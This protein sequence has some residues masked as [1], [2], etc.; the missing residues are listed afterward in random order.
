MGPPLH[1]SN[2]GSSKEHAYKRVLFEDS[3]NLERTHSKGREK[4][5][6]QVGL[7]LSVGVEE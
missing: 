4:S 6:S 7:K 1:P 3:V 5:K 2:S